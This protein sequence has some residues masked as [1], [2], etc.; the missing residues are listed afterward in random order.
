MKLELTKVKIA[1]FASHETLCFEAVLVVDGTPVATVRNDGQG[2]SNYEHV[3]KGQEARFAAAEAWVKA[4]PPVVCKDIPDHADPSKPFTFPM[5]LE[6]Y[7]TG[8]V[9]RWDNEKRLKRDLAKYVYVKTDKG[10][11]SYKVKPT[12]PV[13]PG[14]VKMLEKKYGSY[15]VVN[16]LPL[17]E[18]YTIV[19]GADA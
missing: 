4:L 12:D 13:D 2:G 1:K 9:E 14:F 8:L 17:D 11:V 18:A 10:V 7:V 15:T 19:F 6:Y 3:I 5:S 16:F